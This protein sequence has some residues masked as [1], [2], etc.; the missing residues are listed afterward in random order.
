MKIEEQNI[1]NSALEVFY[2]KP[3]QVKKL[4]K[5]TNNKKDKSRSTSPKVKRRSPSKS[6]R[7]DN[8]DH[9]INN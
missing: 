2:L 3:F 9:E 6:K 7:T 1:L 8:P 5:G 4:N